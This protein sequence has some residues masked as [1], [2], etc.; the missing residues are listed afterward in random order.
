MPLAPWSHFINKV[1][2]VNNCHFHLGATSLSKVKDVDKC[3]FSHLSHILLSKVNDVDKCHL[4]RLSHFLKQGQGCWQM[5]L[6]RLSH[7]CEKAR[8]RMLA[9]ATCH[10]WAT[11]FKSKVKD[12]G[13]CHFSPWSHFS[14]RSKMLTNPTFHLEAFFFKARSKMLAHATLTLQPLF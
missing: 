3:H 7:F 8:S 10:V 6:S 14:T 12:V 5:P 4:S 13:K 2:D 9:N 1:N 11:F